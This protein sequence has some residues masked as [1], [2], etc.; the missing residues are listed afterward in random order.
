[1]LE[2]LLGGL[3][4]ENL[5][6]RFEKAKELLEAVRKQTEEKVEEGVR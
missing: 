6:L 4:P 5:E 2:G 1:V 3:T